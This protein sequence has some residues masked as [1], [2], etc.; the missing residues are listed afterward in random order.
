MHS[1][2]RQKYHDYSHQNPDIDDF[3]VQTSTAAQNLLQA[4]NIKKVPEV[5]DLE[6]M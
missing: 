2:K 5:T 3:I 1:Y 6:L 4:I